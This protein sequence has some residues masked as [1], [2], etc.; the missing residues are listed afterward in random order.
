MD[1]E[2]LMITNDR[3]MLILLRKITEYQAGKVQK[4]QSSEVSVI[5][6]M[7]KPAETELLE[8]Y[9]INYLA[10]M[11]HTTEIELVKKMLEDKVLDKGN[12]GDFPPNIKY[13]RLNYFID[14]TD[15]DPDVYDYGGSSHAWLGHYSLSK[16]GL[17]Y[18]IGYYNSYFNPKTT[19]NMLA[20]VLS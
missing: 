20:D 7:D 5:P 2:A 8:F 1:Y 10:K 18:F 16:N 9:T 15:I 13:I 4:E 17:A 6:V 14:L 3:D 11:L 19:N 12:L